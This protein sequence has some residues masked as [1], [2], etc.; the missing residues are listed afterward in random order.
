VLRRSATW[1]ENTD[2]QCRELTAKDLVR[3]G[4]LLQPPRLF[5]LEPP[6]CNRRGSMVGVAEKRLGDRLEPRSVLVVELAHVAV[7]RLDAH[8]LD[9]LQDGRRGGLVDDD[10]AGALD[11]HG[12]GLVEEVDVEAGDDVDEEE[13]DV[14]QEL[15][16]RLERLDELGRRVHELLGQHR[17]AD[18]L[19]QV[20][21]FGH[22]GAV[23][24]R[25][26]EQ[27]AVGRDVDGPEV[28]ELLAGH[29]AAVQ[30]RALDDEAAEGVADKDDGPLQALLKLRREVSII[31]RAGSRGS[32]VS[33]GGELGGQGLGMV[34][35]V[36]LGGAVGERGDVGVVAVGEDAHA[37]AGEDARE[38]VGG[39]ED[40]GRAGPGVPGMA[41]EPV[42]ED[43]AVRSC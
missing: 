18:V 34:V 22:V 23:V 16:V 25:A 27:D 21:P 30:E 1:L 10:L 13:V 42:H 20:A 38:Q 19:Q 26:Q 9:A 37:F 11:V 17:A 29:A 2:G 4:F 14:L 3:L 24:R 36:V 7:V 12:F 35:E 40:A 8:A 41:V 43:D 28:L 31:A 39:P 32:H 15:V 5:L 6:A 33:V